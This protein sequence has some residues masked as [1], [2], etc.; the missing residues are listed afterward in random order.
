MMCGSKVKWIFL[1]Y[2][3]CL[4]VYGLEPY[5]RECGRYRIVGQVV[6]LA[7]HSGYGIVANEK[8]YSK[9]AMR[10]P[11]SLEPKFIPYINRFVSVIG[12]I[13]KVENIS[14][15]EL[16]ALKSVSIYVPQ[17]GEIFRETGFEL[18]EKLKCL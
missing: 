1:I 11:Q 14:G 7:E 2:F 12:E 18:I 4:S 17:N 10:I 3:C 9:Y 15:G 13:R 5:P 16:G 6:S 8:T